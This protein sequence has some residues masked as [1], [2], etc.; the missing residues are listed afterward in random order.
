MPIHAVAV[1][2]VAM[3]AVWLGLTSLTG[4]AVMGSAAPGAD[5][6]RQ[7]AAQGQ[8]QARPSAALTPFSS[9][10]L[11]RPGE[12]GWSKT[13]WHPTKPPTVY[14]LVEDG[15]QRVLEAVSDASVAGLTHPVSMSPTAD[16]AI[17]WRWKIDATLPGADVGDRQA[18]DSPARLVLAFDGDV[19]SLSMK[20]QMFRERVKLLTGQDL[21]FATLMYVW[22]NERPV[23]TVVKS[24]HTEQIRKLV[25]E[26]GPQGAR[27][28]RAYRRNIAA[29]YALAFGESP[30]TLKAVGVMT[31]ADNTRQKARCLY[32]DIQLK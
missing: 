25:V 31:D 10:T 17:E 21:P 16:S 30:G 32:G 12:P 11:V 18:D 22:D 14:R 9:G 28:W 7:A 26:S 2:R 13:A 4:C 29:D 15:G 5:A 20:E 1:R 19:A 23:G 3:L 24:P 27:Q 8:G 6:S